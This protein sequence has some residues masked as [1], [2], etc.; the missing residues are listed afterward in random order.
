ML[1]KIKDL[2]ETLKANNLIMEEYQKSFE[3]KLYEEKERNHETVKNDYNVPYLTNLNEDPFL[4]Y[5]IYHNFVNKKELVIGKGNKNYEPDII[6]RGIGIQEKH[7]I[8]YE[9]DSKFYIE[10][11]D[12]KSSEYMCVNGSKIKEKKELNNLDRIAIGFN[13]ILLFKNPL[14]PEAPFGFESEKDIDWEKAQI[15]IQDKLIKVN[16]NAEE[17][18]KNQ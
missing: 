18:L 15:E 2:E 14:R 5:K 7:A 9:E 1:K 8:L 12:E 17:K 10:P 11:C 16:F 13:T 3:E 6:I 4:S